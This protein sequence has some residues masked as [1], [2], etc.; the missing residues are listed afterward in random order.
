[1]VLC[2]EGSIKKRDASC[3]Y[4]SLRKVGSVVGIELDILTSVAERQVRSRLL[5]IMNNPLHCIISRHKSSFNDRQLSLFCSTDRLRSCF[6]P[7]AMKL[8]NSTR[9]GGSQC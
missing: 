3:P 6:L 5:S 8:F 9:G 2:W 4:K 7:D 1:M